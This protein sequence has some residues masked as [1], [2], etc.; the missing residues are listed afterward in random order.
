[1]NADKNR[2]LF[3]W[4][5][6]N[7]IFDLDEKELELAVKKT[8]S[9]WV[10]MDC[11]FTWIDWAAEFINSIWNYKNFVIVWSCLNQWIWWRG[12]WYLIQCIHVYVYLVE[13]LFIFSIIHSFMPHLYHNHDKNDNIYKNINITIKIYLLQ[14][15]MLRY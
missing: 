2:F 11:E 10:L 13:R 8:S 3:C 6:I 9:R 4:I 14:I 1:M 5:F 7:N 15:L 12:R